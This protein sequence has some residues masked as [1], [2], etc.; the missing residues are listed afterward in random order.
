M[1]KQNQTGTFP[2]IKG[3]L[4]T[5]MAG[6]IQDQW[7]DLLSKIDTEEGKLHSDA[8]FPF[9]DLNRLGSMEYAELVS[10]DNDTIEEFVWQLDEVVRRIEIH[11]GRI[12]KIL[13]FIEEKLAKAIAAVPSDLLAFQDRDVKCRILASHYPVVQY[14]LD[15]KDDYS[16]QSLHWRGLA[17]NME[18]K[19]WSLKYR[20]N[21]GG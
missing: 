8:E 16:R 19:A 20:L 7:V 9:D 2:R 5:N 4:D 1:D 13:R 6:G 14:L 17:K 10:Y 11:E 21:K 15:Q 18:K 12:Q 3:L